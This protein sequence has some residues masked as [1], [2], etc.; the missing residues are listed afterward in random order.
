VTEQQ[1]KWL[2]LNQYLQQLEVEAGSLKNGNSD[3]APDGD[4][5]LNLALEVLV[6][7]DF[8][9][10]W[11]VAKIFPKLGIGGTGLDPELKAQLPHPAIAPLVAILA[12]E[13]AEPELRWFAARILGESPHPQAITA[14]VE[15]LK[16][17]EDEDLREI[18]ATAIANLGATAVQLLAPLLA[19]PETRL[20]GIQGLVGINSP[21][22]VAPLMTVAQDPEVAVRIAVISAL[23][24]FHESAVIPVL[25]QALQDLAAPVRKEA[26]IAL[27]MRPEL[28]AEWDL[29]ADLQPLIFDL[30]LEVGTA[31]TIALGR[32]RTDAAATALFQ[33][34]KSVPSTLQIT[35]IR[36]LGWMETPAALAYLGEILGQLS[37]VCQVE[38]I[39]LLGRVTNP[40]MKPLAAQ[41]LIDFFPH[42]NVQDAQTKCALALAWGQLGNETAIPLLVEMLADVDSGVKLH[43]IAAL[44]NFPRVTKEGYLF[45][46]P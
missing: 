20:L 42:P 13:G 7:G 26:A 41:I 43:A 44:K 25:R 37:A 1:E 12:D 19:E 46:N 40:A 6:N 23:S 30:N 24:N 16:T 21:E 8:Q 22:I 17:S 29:V 34:L 45:F 5:I 18:A 35:I 39:A 33:A 38:A 2:V 31:A 27:G 15:L 36:A 11:E 32:L 4:E 9:D 3:S 28:L 10:R 14:L